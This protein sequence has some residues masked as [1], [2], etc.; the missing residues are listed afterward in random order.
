VDYL[1]IEEVDKKGQV[2]RLS[3][4]GRYFEKPWKIRADDTT[5]I[6]RDTCLIT[7]TDKFNYNA[8]MRELRGE[9]PQPRVASLLHEPLGKLDEFNIDFDPEKVKGKR[10]LICFWDMNQRPSR[11]CM[12]QLAKRAE[13]LNNNSVIT[14]AVQASK[15]E[16]ETLNQ[17]VKKYNIPFPI[18]MV[19]GD[20]KKACF[21]WG[22]KSLPWLILTDKQHV[23][24]AEGLGIEEIVDKI[25]NIEN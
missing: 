24:Q 17:W 14:V 23:V 18:G 1:Y 6:H 8:K 10:I 21:D 13:Q 7:E 16:V 19:Q 20:A 3:K 9:G 12:I 2:T 11:H 15:I 5:I 25:K 4:S 22:V